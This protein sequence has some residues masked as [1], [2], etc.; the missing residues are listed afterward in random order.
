MYLG[1]LRA[2]LLNSC[3]G[4][5][6]RVFFYITFGYFQSCISAHGTETYAGKKIK[7]AM[8]ITM[9]HKFWKHVILIY[10]WVCI[11]IIGCIA[12]FFLLLVIVINVV[13][14]M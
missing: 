6:L 10:I 13:V 3:A 8:S 14:S 7:I 9:I 1:C 11:A 4:I 5:Y 2:I 12:I